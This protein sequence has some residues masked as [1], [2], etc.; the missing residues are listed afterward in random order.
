MMELLRAIR[1][2]LSGNKTY[3]GMIAMGILGALWNQGVIDD[4]M[5]K[6]IGS[7]LAAMTGVAV[8]SAWAKGK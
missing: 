4:M 5:A 8:R 7:L 1:K 3:I 2:T 6:T